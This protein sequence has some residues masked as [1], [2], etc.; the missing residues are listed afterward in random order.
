[1]KP[2]YTQKVLIGKNKRQ[3][4][5]I[6]RKNNNFTTYIIKDKN[7][8]L[9]TSRSTT[10]TINEEEAIKRLAKAVRGLSYVFIVPVDLKKEKIQERYL[11][12]NN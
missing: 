9:I 1:M 8:R 11:K 3:A 2:D 10:K 5:L 7:M 12:I 4:V 6:T